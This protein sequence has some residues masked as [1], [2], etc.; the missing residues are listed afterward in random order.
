MKKAKRKTTQEYFFQCVADYS[1]KDIQ[2]LKAEKEILTI[3]LHRQEE[4]LKTRFTFKDYVFVMTF[5]AAIYKVL[6]MEKLFYSLPLISSPQ[7]TLYLTTL[8]LAVIC[9][10][11]YVNEK[12]I[13]NNK[14][15]LDTM[16]RSINYCLDNNLYQESNEDTGET[17]E[18]NTEQE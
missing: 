15:Y 8:L 2:Y 11:N 17:D 4:R 1:T 6:D 3:E 13:S 12:S 7:V 9:I 10:L 18:L 16:I 14:L 5:F